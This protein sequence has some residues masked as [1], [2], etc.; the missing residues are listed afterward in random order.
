MLMGSKIIRAR[1]EDYEAFEHALRTLKDMRMRNY[2]AFGPTNLNEIEDLMPK[3]GSRVRLWATIGAIIGLATFWIMCIT[4][5]LIYSL[6]TGAKPPVSNVPFIIPA[7]EG[8]ILVGSIAAFLAAV[9][10]A[11]FTPFGLP[12]G[13]DPR[14]SEDIYGVEVKCAPKDTAR[15]TNMLKEA[16]AVEVSE[17]E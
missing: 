13:Y 4:T 9:Y 1:F 12:K 8:T 6:Y 11:R 2:E 14:F 16:G 17:I 3:K 15:I 7:Y 10:Y 5:S